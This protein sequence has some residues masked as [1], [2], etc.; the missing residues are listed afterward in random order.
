MTTPTPETFEASLIAALAKRHGLLSPTPETPAQ[1]KAQ[2]D[3]LLVE[4]ERL[5]ELL[6]H[7][8]QTTMRARLFGPES[9][10]SYRSACVSAEGFAEDALTQQTKE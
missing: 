1:I 3:E 6:K 8:K 5:R 10:Q 7:I 4:V 2:R 9:M